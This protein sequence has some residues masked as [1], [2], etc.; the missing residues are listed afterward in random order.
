[1]IV[2]V[3]HAS[4]LAPYEQIRS[5]ITTMVLTGSLP[6]ETRLPPIRQL[7]SDLGIS[8]GTV[9]RAYRELEGDG[10]VVSRGRRGTF[11]CPA[12][13]LPVPAGR[14][15]L[16]AE[17]AQAYALRARQLRADEDSALEAVRQALTGTG[18]DGPEQ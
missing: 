9:A 17:A 2:H 10:I 12:E 1:M 16:L 5:Q 11:T 8:P 15:E 4:G 13:T 3:D 7:A 18:Q 6:A 14:D